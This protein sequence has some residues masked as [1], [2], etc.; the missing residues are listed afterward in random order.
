MYLITITSRESTHI[1]FTEECVTKEEVVV[2]IIV[3]IEKDK[4]KILP[5]L[6]SNKGGLRHN[7]IK[8]NAIEF[9]TS[10]CKKQT[11]NA[12][13]LTFEYISQFY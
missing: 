9:N 10:L 5:C 13:F 11:R 7:N 6:I 8:R 2:R 12:Q 4:L 1:V 3:S